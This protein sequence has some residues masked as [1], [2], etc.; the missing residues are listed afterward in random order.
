MNHIDSVSTTQKGGPLADMK[1][2]VEWLWIL[3]L[4]VTGCLLCEAGTLPASPARL[5]RIDLEVARH[6]VEE[7][8]I[9]QSAHPRPS[10][11]R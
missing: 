9:D 1:P 4:S 7:T 3:V 11:L 8:R 5:M 10:E 2:T 6:L